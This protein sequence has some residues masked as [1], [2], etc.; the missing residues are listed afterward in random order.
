MKSVDT[1]PSDASRN[2][3]GLKSRVE[4]LKM[5]ME[6][7]PAAVAMCDTKMRYLAY[8]RRWA[9][10]YGF[11]EGNIRLRKRPRLNKLFSNSFL[12][13]R[14]LIPAVRESQNPVSISVK[15]KPVGSALYEVFLISSSRI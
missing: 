14:Q 8:S 12:K 11:Q 10:D 3:A 9:E 1:I 6:H 5:F 4:L 15:N 7:T 13:Q 2:T